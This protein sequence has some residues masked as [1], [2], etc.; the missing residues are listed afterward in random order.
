MFT[1]VDLRRLGN[2]NYYDFLSVVKW[3]H[4]SKISRIFICTN[5]AYVAVYARWMYVCM[6]TLC[7]QISALWNVQ[8]THTTCRRLHVFDFRR[9]RTAYSTPKRQEVVQFFI[10]NIF[11]CNMDT[12]FRF[13]Y[14]F[15]NTCP[16]T[17]NMLSLYLKNTPKPPP[18]V[19]TRW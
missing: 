8:V 12:S 16:H 13:F 2:V 9:L 19:R 15:I 4:K 5:S 7:T 6:Q 17:I 18:W 10:F 11:N 1:H 3:Y 14:K